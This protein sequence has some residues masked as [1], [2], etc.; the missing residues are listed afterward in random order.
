VSGWSLVYEG[1][2]PAGEGLR[3]AL[4][5]LG[6]GFFATRGAGEEA[7]A[8][9]TRYPGTYV[10]G[11]YDRLVT[12]V[13]GRAI[14]NEDLVNF[15]NWLCLR[16]RPAGGD[17]LS[18][19]DLEVL[20]YRQELDL[21]RGILTR[22]MRLGDGAG[23][24]T[25]LES[26]R[27]V[28]LREPHLAAIELTVVPENWSGRLELVSGLDGRVTNTGV[29]RYRQ[30]DGRHLVALAAA[31]VDEETV[32]LS[33]ETRQSRLRVA[34]AA[35]S[36]VTR[37]GGLAPVARRVLEEPG[38]VGLEHVVEV[39]EGHPV[40]LEKVVA[41]FTSRDH[42]VSECS[43]A[44]REAVAE[45]PGFTPLAAS[46][47]QAWDH[48]WRRFEVRLDGDEPGT[49]R[50]A[51]VLRLHVFHLLQTTYRAVDRDAGVPARGLHGEAYRGHVFWDELFIFPFL[52]LRM[53]ELT[54]AL[55]R[56]RYRRLG[57]ARRA[58]RA[59]GLR[60]ACYPWQSGS[61]GREE[62]QTLHL[63]PRSGRWS[64]DHSRRQ[65]HVNAAIVFNL[66][67]YYQV[68]R[69]DQFLSSYGAEIILEVARLWAS[70]SSWS[71]EHDRYEIRG[72][73]GPDEFHDAYP[74]AGAPGLDNNAYTN[75][76]AVYC[77]CRAR[78]A[79]RVL[80][81]HRAFELREVLGLGDE[82]LAH[83]E[84][85][86]RRMRLC[87]HGD[88]LISQFEGWERLEEL[89]WDAYRKRYG[90]V[91]R[92]DRILEAEGDSTNR[93]KLAKQPDVL[94]LFYLF[95]AEELSGLFERLSYPW[96]R[97]TIPRNVAYYSARTAHGSTL[98]RVV[99]SWVLARSDR[100]R[101]WALFQ[102]AL[103]SDV[104]DIQ[105]GTTAEGI[106]LGAMA[107]TV[108]LVQ[109]AYTGLEARGDV[110]RFAPCLPEALKSL[111]LHLSYRG[112]ALE[113]DLSPRRL[114]VRALPSGAP[115]I[116]LAVRGREVELAAGE[117]K[118]R[119]TA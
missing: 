34:L 20:E 3:E 17:W 92:L 80:P 42:A 116:R 76:M 45:A 112:Q 101:S 48:L 99:H 22:R 7:E 15:P 11:G 113:V 13:A 33:V 47:E 32:A 118:E 68:T 107:G 14:E 97:E 65:R 24:R 77:L 39:A 46:H 114:R 67:H 12:E 69:D 59:E 82:E 60:G 2:D 36:R 18:P 86:S 109:R 62:S 95:S 87:F 108:D 89:D 63:N 98:S 10:A 38:Y 5:T 84:D 75:L 90:D 115:P 27:L 53:P 26:R 66:W 52:N 102:E 94:M 4:C 61:D 30:L 8:D 83:W 37:H 70:L 78:D 79:L 73:L 64:P 117:E 85:V 111:H 31:L 56:Y 88:G 55:L 16:A 29:A 41:M 96:D 103:E 58:A 49:Q 23:R 50:A 93:Y 6:N 35:R 21:R 1:W 91:H 100:P 54:R 71:S 74:W 19:S 44:A 9:G 105:G 104:A 51:L 57:A 40:R 72:V 25:L 28:H 81:E 110:L 119:A 106:H 43:L